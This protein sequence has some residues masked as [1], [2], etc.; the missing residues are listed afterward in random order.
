M[1]KS[2]YNY[3]VYDDGRVFSH[4]SNKFLKGEKTV[5]GY[6]QYSLYLDNGKI[7]KIRK[8]QLVANLFL[9]KPES[10]EKLIVNHKDGNKNN[11]SYTNLEWTT[12][13]G[14]NKHARDNKLNDVS[15]SNSER[16][17]DSEFRKK[18]SKNISEGILKSGSSKGQKN[19]RFRYLIYFNGNIID[20]CDLSKRLNLSQS[21]TDRLIKLAADGKEIELFKNLN[22]YIKNTK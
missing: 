2:F 6:I 21:Y 14:N 12:Y 16:W 3:D 19:G 5:H 18:V 8:H 10:D 15:K 13:Y 20:R 1:F 11:C 22:I 4:Y 9:E 7:L 17:K